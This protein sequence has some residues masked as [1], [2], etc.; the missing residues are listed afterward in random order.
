MKI[1]SF[2]NSLGNRRPVERNVQTWNSFWLE[3]VSRRIT[4]PYTL[5]NTFSHWNSIIYSFSN[6]Y[7]NESHESSWQFTLEP[8]SKAYLTLQT[9]GNSHRWN[10]TSV[11][12][13]VLCRGAISLQSCF[14]PSSI[15]SGLGHSEDLCNFLCAISV[16]SQ[17]QIRALA[18]N[19]KQG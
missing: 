1:Y 10:H 13:L 5:L 7:K 11:Y 2:F 18:A 9:M 17:K 15:Q 12:L 8:K 19:L 3:I 14:S 16:W 4:C 6:T